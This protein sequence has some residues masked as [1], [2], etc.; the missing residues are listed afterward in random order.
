LARTRD[1]SFAAGARLVEGSGM[2][3]LAAADLDGDGAAD[4]AAVDEKAGEIVL[5]FGPRRR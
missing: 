3:R 5:W 2:W 1:G 4:L